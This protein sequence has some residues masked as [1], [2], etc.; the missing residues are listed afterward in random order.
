MKNLKCIFLLQ[1]A[2][3][4]SLFLAS[5]VFS[6]SLYPVPSRYSSIELHFTAPHLKIVKTSKGCHAIRGRN[7]S[8]LMEPG[9]PRLPEITKMVSLPR[10]VDINSISIRNIEVK[11]SVLQGNYQVEPVPPLMF[12][13]FQRREIEWGRNKK[14]K[15]GK[16]TLIYSSS[17]PYPAQPVRLLGSIEK[18]ERRF[19]RMAFYPVRYY[20]KEGKIELINKVSCKL[21]FRTLGEAADNKQETAGGD[22]NLMEEAVPAPELTLTNDLVPAGT[23]YDYVIIT[24]N[25]VVQ[26][27]QKLADFI[28]M[29]K[30]IGHSVLVVTE[31]QY[32]NLEGQAPNGRAEKIRKWLIDNYQALGIKYVLL[33]GNP[34]PSNGDVPMKKCYPRSHETSYRESVTDYYYADLTGN[35]D[36]DGDGLY[37]E[38]PDDNLSGGVDY[39]AEVW[40]GRIP[41]YNDDYEIL[42]QI[43]QKI[44]DYETESDDLSWRK[45]ALLP[46]AILNFEQEPP[47]NISRT[48]GA[49]LARQIINGYLRGDGFLKYSLFEKEGIDPCPYP[50]DSSLTRTN[51]KDAWV[52]EYGL[53][54]AVGH[55]SATGIYRKYWSYDDNSNNLADSDETVITS[56]FQSSDT[57]ALDDT[58]PSIVYLC[59]CNNGYP[60]NSGNL[61]Y[62]LLKSGAVATVSASRVSWYTAGWSEPNPNYGDNFS[63]GYYYMKKVA[64]DIPCGEALALTKEKLVYNSSS[65]WLNLQGFN[66]YGDPETRLITT[67]TFCSY[68]F[69]HDGDVD[70]EDL[71]SLASENED[72]NLVELSEQFG[73][74]HCLQ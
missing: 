39:A 38:Y 29:K 51:V 22:G 24:S 56:F 27:S 42:D 53:V 48:D 17:E 11:A 12:S 60:E 73:K 4:I 49:D 66:L 46:A 70:G 32:L 8:Y 26:N 40:V 65:I 30:A 55:G 9:N 69:D 33:I 28:S 18:G 14:I 63:I 36:I 67:Y 19:L 41:V 47:S 13:G 5:N 74:S 2:L 34:D 71:A 43:L 3:F 7:V 68:D 35:W 64:E 20:P 61:G 37:G 23:I 72:V 1:V 10:G 45:E 16:N 25:N 57:I 54:C 31:D 58:Y 52:N 62:S 59:A 21:F 44:I 15:Y 50:S 6:K